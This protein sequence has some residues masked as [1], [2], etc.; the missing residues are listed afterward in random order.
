M[1]SVQRKIN[2][3]LA[4]STGVTKM[5]T[6]PLKK[7]ER[8][9]QKTLRCYGLLLQRNVVCVCVCVCV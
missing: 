5:Q 9:I 1:N 6:T 3:Y 2:G 7:T 8:A 4:T